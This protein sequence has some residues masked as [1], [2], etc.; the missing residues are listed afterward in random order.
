MAAPGVIAK[1]LDISDR[2]PSFPGVYGFVQI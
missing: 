2:V 1:E